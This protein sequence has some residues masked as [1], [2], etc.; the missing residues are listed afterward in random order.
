MKSFV[1]AVCLS[2]LLGG[3]AYWVLTGKVQQT[4]EVAF[5][6]TGVRL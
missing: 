1:I 4:A 3:T 2:V 5:S 6:T